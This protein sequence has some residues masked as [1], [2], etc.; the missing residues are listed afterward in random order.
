MRPNFT[1]RFACVSALVAIVLTA[2]LSSLAAAAIRAS[3]V[4]QEARQVADQAARLLSQSFTR[5]EFTRGLGAETL[6]GLDTLSTDPKNAHMLRVLLWNRDGTLLYSN[7]RTGIGRRMPISDGL[8]VAVGGSTAVLPLDPDRLHPFSAE[9]MYLSVEGY[10]EY[11]LFQRD[12]VWAKPGEPAPPPPVTQASIAKATSLGVARLFLPVRLDEA[13]A[14]VGAFEVFYDFRPLEHKLAQMRHTVW[15]TIPGG[16]FALYCSLLVVVQRTSRVLVQ[17][18]EDL[19]VA[20][21][22]TFHALASAVDARDSDTGDHS[23]R[24][25]AYAVA[26]ARRLGLGPEAIA[27]LKIAAELHDIGKIGVPDTVLMKPGPLT[28]GEWELMRQHA[29]IGSS[30][31]H[32]TPLSE[33]IKLA[34]RHVHERW[35][36][37]G[38]PDRLAGDAIPL[39][40]R[41]LAAADAFEAMTSDRPYRRALSPARALAELQRMRSA[42]FD[43]AIVDALWAVAKDTNLIQTGGADSQAS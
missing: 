36:G 20:H 43:P 34:V 33:T 42:Q 16:F 1:L 38:Y 41:I 24:V 39:F 31:L 35:D 17:Q 32:S 6:A 14:P 13:S 7:D 12:R 18:R 27:E 37:Q 22:G 9:T 26:A 11:L 21:L 28:S 30:I 15:A 23:G 19:R 40:A 10:L 8:R 2:S 4:E 3:A 5:D 25:A 29:I